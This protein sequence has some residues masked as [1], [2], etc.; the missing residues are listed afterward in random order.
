MKTNLIYWSLCLLLAGMECGNASAGNPSAA[1]GKIK[2]QA[3]ALDGIT[4]KAG[5]TAAERKRLC[6]DATPFDELN[7]AS[8]KEIA[9]G[10]Q[11]YK[12]PEGTLE[13]LAVIVDDHGTFTYLASYDVQGKLLDCIQIASSM[14]YSGDEWKS[15]VEGN[16]VKTRYAWAEPMAEWGEG[17]SAL[18]T[19]T[20]DL[21]FAP[22]SWPP[23]DFP[24]ETPFMTHEYDG[25]VPFCWKIESVVCTGLSDSAYRFSVKGRGTGGGCKG[26]DREQLNI[27]FEPINSRWEPAGEAVTVTLPAVGDGEAFEAEIRIPKGKLDEKTFAK[28]QLI[29]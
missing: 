3:N 8:N 24:A 21:H 11:I 7:K 23:K 4:Y 9:R 5:I 19:V 10:K 27:R 25:N 12:G 26:A 1:D 14:M 2:L 16:R 22:F 15:T 17:I 28:F 6:I 13:T 29:R 20:D 18:H